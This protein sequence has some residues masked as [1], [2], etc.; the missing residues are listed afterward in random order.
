MSSAVTTWDK[1]SPDMEEMVRWRDAW[2]EDK[3]LN[4]TRSYKGITDRFIVFL[5]EGNEFINP[6]DA[7]NKYLTSRRKAGN[8]DSTIRKIKIGMRSFL[9]YLEREQRLPEGTARK[10]KVGTAKA[11]IKERTLDKTRRL[12]LSECAINPTLA[13]ILR[14]LYGT[15]MRITECLTI[16]RA[17]LKSPEE[18]APDQSHGSCVVVGKGG[19][20]RTIYTK[21]CLIQELKDHGPKNHAHV[22]TTKTGT[23]LQY[24]T[25]HRWLKQTKEGARLADS[26]ISPHWWRHAHA[27]DSL[28]NKAP[29]NVLSRTLGHR[30]L[31]TTALYLHAAE[32]STSAGYLSDSE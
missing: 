6:M 23:P 18:A 29:I 16:E 8:K 13:L 26:G 19:V 3:P 21:A 24:S 14:T 7:V 31:S 9:S 1:K 25:V 32:T 5:A 27:S 12:K 17:T 10:L 2:L 30:Q 20:R 4:T 15:G 28:R 22:F 11:A